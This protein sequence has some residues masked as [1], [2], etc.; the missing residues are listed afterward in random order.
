MYIPKKVIW[1]KTSNNTGL[2][3][4]RYHIIIKK[5]NDK[6][7]YELGIDFDKIAIHKDCINIL[8][9]EDNIKCNTFE[10]C[11]TIYMKLIY[12]K[13]GLIDNISQDFSIE[14]IN[15][16]ISRFDTIKKSNISKLKLVGE[17]YLRENGYTSGL[18]NN[19]P[20][21]TIDLGTLGWILKNY[22][23]DK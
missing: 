8:V 15:F 6:Y 22:D 23:N 5:E 1:Q 17:S 3:N 13:F 18:Q 21:S 4:I 10:Y 11:A 12:P 16:L 2:D 7:I 9:Q 20:C 14:K 19:N